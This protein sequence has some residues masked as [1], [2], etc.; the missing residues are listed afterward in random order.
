[1]K[2]LIKFFVTYGIYFLFA[3]LEIG[4]LLMVVNYNHFQ[5]SVFLT[6]CNSFTATIYQ[7]NQQVW[8][9]FELR[10]VNQELASE[11]AYLKQKVFLLDNK[12]NSVLG[13]SVRNKKIRL[14]PEKEY[15]CYYARVINNST[16]KQQN[17]I[18]INRGYK[19]GI[20]EDMSV[21]NPRGVVGIITS[22]SK[23]FAVVMPILNPKAQISCK[24]KGKTAL[25]KDTVGVVKDIG[26]L[27]WDGVD[28]LH[29]LMVQVPRHVPIRVGDKIITSGYSDFFPEGILVGEVES[30]EKASDDNYYD[31]TVRLSVN[32]KT[33][34]YVTVLD[35]KHREEQ[36]KLEELS[37]E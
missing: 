26:S 33:I 30:F 24:I 35:Y 12:L 4:S 2:T 3:I 18:T 7:Y 32:F 37:K 1:M 6:S 29:A 13:D 21:I 22:V 17:F 11:N 5:R 9:Y 20:R 23:N 27:K 28:P 34:S 14:D 8:S 15:L 10:E 31:I 36:E 19:D 25:T 16:N